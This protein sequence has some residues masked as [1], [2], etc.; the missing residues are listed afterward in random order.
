MCAQ[1]VPFL[2]GG[3]HR[4]QRVAM[5]NRYHTTGKH[6]KCKEERSCEME[7]GGS[8][9]ALNNIKNKSASS[10]T[11]VEIIK[12]LSSGAHTENI[13][14]AQRASQ[15]GLLRTLAE[16]KGCSSCIEGKKRLGKTSYHVQQVSNNLFWGGAEDR[17]QI[18]FMGVCPRSEYLRLRF[19]NGSA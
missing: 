11:A 16:Y 17:R 18:S 12:Q 9:A 14:R 2:P 4:L 1:S 8:A 7:G 13:T 6:Q 10:E 5:R 15:H 3:S 19:R